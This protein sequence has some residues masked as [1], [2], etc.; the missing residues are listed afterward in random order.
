MLSRS[1]FLSAEDPQTDSLATICWYFFSLCK[2][3]SHGK[4][5]MKFETKGWLIILD[6]ITLDEKKV[7][8]VI[9]IEGPLLIV[10]VEDIHFSY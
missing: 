10:S 9:F 3:P 8:V 1:C 4:K 6:L 7:V 2:W 5:Y